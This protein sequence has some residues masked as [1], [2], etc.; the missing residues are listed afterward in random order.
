MNR[1]PD[2]IIRDH[3]PWAISAFCR[4]ACAGLSLVILLHLP[5]HPLVMAAGALLLVGLLYPYPLVCAAGFV[6]VFGI[7]LPMIALEPFRGISR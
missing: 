4:G 6:L 3:R 1:T 7:V 2:E 5:P